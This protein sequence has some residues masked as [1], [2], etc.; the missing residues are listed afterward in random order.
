MSA[1]TVG[2]APKVAC[3]A[4]RAAAKYEIVGVAAGAVTC[5][6]D[7]LGATLVSCPAFMQAV[8]AEVITSV[9]NAPNRVLGMINLRKK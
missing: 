2:F 4:N 5:P 3:S 6:E 7:A 9:L 8:R 1:T